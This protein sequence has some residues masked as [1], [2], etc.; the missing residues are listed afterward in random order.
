MKNL[1]YIGNKLSSHGYTITTIESLGLLLEKENYNVKYA[2]D[3]KNKLLRLLDMLGATIKHSST[4]DYVI[5]DTYGTQNFWYAF[6]VSQLC[7]LLNKKYIPI[8]HGGNL[9]ERLQEKSGICQM[10][11]SKAHI[12]VAPS[13]YFYSLFKQHGYKNLVAIPN[14]IETENYNFRLR[15]TI[16]P[17]LLWVRSLALTYNPAMAIRVLA[18]LKKE[19]ADAELFMVGPDKEGLMPSLS[20][21][22]KE[23]NVEVTFTGHL[24]KADWITLSEQFDI[25]INTT[26]L[27]NTPVSVIEAMALGLP[28]ISTKVGGIPFLL[29]HNATALLVPDNDAIEMTAAVRTLIND[30]PLAQAMTVNARKLA[31]DFDWHTVKHKWF[32]ILT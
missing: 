15:E 21:L 1:L 30:V 28:V 23:L 20:A 32:E 26:H 11:F 12:N 16:R 8:L 7:R 10:I 17:K 14:I 5:I 13:P 18:E 29:D 6:L 2:S 25:F 22:A 19:Y 4:T 9:P 24:A 27:D 3:K 31:L